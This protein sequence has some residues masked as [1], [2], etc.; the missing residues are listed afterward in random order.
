MMRRVLCLS[1]LAAACATAP[2]APAKRGVVE[3]SRVSIGR[4]G[5]LIVLLD[6]SVESD[7]VHEH[8]TL[9]VPGASREATLREPGTCV[10]LQPD[11]SLRRCK[12]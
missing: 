7:A 5:E 12:D 9:Q 8:Y 11:L 1:L 6:V 10:M 3:D 4:D 2:A